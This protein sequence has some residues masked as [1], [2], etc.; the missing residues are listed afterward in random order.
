MEDYTKDKIIGL[1]LRK[2]VF[3]SIERATKYAETQGFKTNFRKRPPKDVGD[4]WLFTQKDYSRFL[5]RPEKES[6]RSAIVYVYGF[7]PKKK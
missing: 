5:S 3:Q 2:T 4:F 7:H 6:S 1:K